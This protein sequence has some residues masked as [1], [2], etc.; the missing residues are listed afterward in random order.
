M[1]ILFLGT[2]S[3]VPTRSRNVTAIA[4]KDSKGSGWSLID[5][6]EGTQHQ[7]LRVK[8]SVNALRAIFITHL[9]GDHC[10]GLPGLLAS[11][12]MS[13]RTKP[14]QLVAPKAVLDWFKATVELTQLHFSFEIEMHEVEQLNTLDIQG[15]SVHPVLLSHRAP[16]YAYVFIKKEI[17]SVLNI[18]K[19]KQ[20]RVPQG[21]VWGQ[22]KKGENVVING[23]EY[24]ASDY[25]FMS[26]Q[27]R[28]VVIAGDNDKPELLTEACK[29]AVVLVH[30]STY[31]KDVAEK[32][33]PAVGHSYAEQV[34]R[35]AES[36]KLPHLILTHFSPRYKP[37]GYSSPSVDDIALEAKAYYSGDL[38][39]AEDFAEYVLD[40]TNRLTLLQ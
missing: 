22:L 30:E 3:G 5:C 7:L 36:V 2:S 37:S 10:Y 4:L 29:D 28:K 32:V 16:S 18:A 6:G 14:L 11:A 25:A 12:A 24:K 35:F 31:T 15:I 8:L 17:K 34:G 1:N 26:D 23:Q 38:F 20:D 9:H 33:G 19:L 13:G 27:S 21:Q 39:L 40:K